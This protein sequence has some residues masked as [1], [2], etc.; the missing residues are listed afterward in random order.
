MIHL[1]QAHLQ[2]FSQCPPSF[3][4]M[5]LEQL[6][7]PIASEQLTKLKW[8]TQFHLVMQ[9]LELG[10][11]LAQLVIP[12]SDLYHAVVALLAQIP[13]F[14]NPHQ[15][16]MAQAEHRRTLKMGHFV[17]TVVYD[18][19]LLSHG[20]TVQ[21]QMSCPQIFDWK[22]YSK[23]KNIEFLRDH[24]QTKLYMY[25]LAKTTAYEPEQISMTYWFVKLP[26]EPQSITFHY[27]QVWHQQVHQEL[28]ALLDQLQKDLDDY[29]QSGNP[30]QHHDRE[31]CPLCLPQFG[32][33]QQSL[34]ASIRDGQSP[35]NFIKNIQEVQL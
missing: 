24:W 5:Y 27:S 31:N 18:W 20:R 26:K 15:K 6:A 1:S 30:L 32:Q 21:A 4:R 23:P 35:E 13:D 34:V 9:Q 28:T 33:S 10:F 2:R 12:D 11:S 7:E 19:V 16:T 29:F 8:G 17:L 22:T 14:A 25:V 3:Q